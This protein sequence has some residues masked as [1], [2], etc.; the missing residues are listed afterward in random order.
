MRKPPANRRRVSVE[1]HPDVRGTWLVF[2]GPSG[3]VIAA[4]VPD[5]GDALDIANRFSAGD[6]EAGPH[7]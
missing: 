1:E 7:D 4:G 6:E 5:I 3:R 2:E